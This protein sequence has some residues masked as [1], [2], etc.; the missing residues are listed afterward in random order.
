MLAGRLFDLTKQYETAVLI[1]AAANVAGLVLALTLPRK[2]WRTAAASAGSPSTER[3]G[4][5]V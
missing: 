2:G 4:R 3:R 1:A 5:A